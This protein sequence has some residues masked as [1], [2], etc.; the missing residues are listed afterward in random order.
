MTMYS[1]HAQISVYYF[2]MTAMQI[3]MKYGLVFHTQTGPLVLWYEPFTLCFSQSDNVK[4]CVV[5]IS[6]VAKILNNNHT[7]Y[8]DI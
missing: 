2:S 1:I 7:A 3:K 8:A 4:K 6:C 5:K